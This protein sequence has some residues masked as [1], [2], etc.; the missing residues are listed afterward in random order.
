MNKNPF[1]H[2]PLY[3]TGSESAFCLPPS[4]YQPCLVVAIDDTDAFHANRHSQTPS[5][6]LLLPPSPLSSLSAEYFP[7]GPQILPFAFGDE[8]A[9]WGELVSVTCS[10]AKGDQ[11]LEISWAFNG[12][13]I[14]SHHGSDVVIGSTNKKNSVLT[15][16]SVA[17]RHAGE[18]TCSASNRAGATT[19]SS[20]LTV[21]GTCVPSV[22]VSVSTFLCSHCPPPSP[23]AAGFSMSVGCTC[24]LSSLEIGSVWPRIH[25][26]SN[27]RFDQI[28]AYFV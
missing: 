22:R 11:P 10:V 28:Y 1:P 27:D 12:T 26:T 7:V 18:Y 14:D 3:Q 20:R 24:E 19:H 5:L 17:A 16:E 4:P 25:F 13:P 21:N 8:P 15:I 6:S 23:I 2:V 9:S